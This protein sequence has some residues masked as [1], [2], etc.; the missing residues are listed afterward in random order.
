MAKSIKKRWLEEGISIKRYRGMVPFTPWGKLIPNRING[1]P[2]T[3]ISNDESKES[4]KTPEGREHTDEKN[5]QNRY[6]TRREEVDEEANDRG[7]M[8][9][10]YDKILSWAGVR[11]R[12][13]SF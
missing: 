6:M 2:T 7:L 1:N 11:K 4:D 3:D 12:A 8:L 9:N 10:I 5:N 13:A